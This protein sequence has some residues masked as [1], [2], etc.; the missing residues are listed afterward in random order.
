MARALSGLTV[1][2]PT[3]R[4]NGRVCG[5]PEVEHQ[6]LI[7]RG[8]DEMMR[9]KGL[10]ELDG[11]AHVTLGA[12][13]RD[14]A[15]GDAPVVGDGKGRIMRAA[16]LGV[17]GPE[18]A[19][20]RHEELPAGATAIRVAVDRGARRGRE[21]HLDAVVGQVGGVVAGGGAFALLVV[22]GFFRLQH[23][24]AAERQQQHVA[25]IG[26]AAA[27][28]VSVREAVHGGV[29]VLIAR[30]VVPGAGAGVGAD[31]REAEWKRGA[32]ERVAQA[33]GADEGI[34]EGGEALVGLRVRRR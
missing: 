19:V 26:H 24:L 22:R 18:N 33:A 9:A 30:D 4:D 1:E 13:A 28:E 12:A 29:G 14:V 8:V 27:A 7:P 31:L 34:D 15:A 25:E 32:G 2:M 21:L 6:F 5:F 23:A 17:S 11:K 16:P 3:P 10:I 20:D